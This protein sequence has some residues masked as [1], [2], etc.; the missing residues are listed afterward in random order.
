MSP[1][2]MFGPEI[3][4]IFVASKSEPIPNARILVPALLIVLATVTALATATDSSTL[5]P[6]APILFGFPSDE[7]MSKF[8]L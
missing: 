7:N 6:E 8:A 3:A 1:V 5:V 4:I 2:S